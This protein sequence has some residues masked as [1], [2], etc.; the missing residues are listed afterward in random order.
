MKDEIYATVCQNPGIETQDVCLLIHDS[1]I[2]NPGLKGWPLAKHLM[3]EH[4]NIWEATCEAVDALCDDNLIF[5]TDN[6]GLYQV[7]YQ[8]ELS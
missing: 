7:G 2:S 4:K 6:G 8:G 1:L 5:F 3:S